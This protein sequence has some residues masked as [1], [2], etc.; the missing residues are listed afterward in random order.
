M[1]GGDKLS[2]KVI[3]PGLLTTVQ[4]LG[5]YG[6]Q[7]YGV[8]V[9]GAMD[10]FSLRVANLLVGNDENAA[11]LEITMMGPTLEILEDTLVSICGG[12]ITAKING[13]PVGQW[14]PVYIKKGSI[15]ELKNCTGG[16]RIYLAIAGGFDV[17]EIMGSKSTY[18]RAGIGGFKGRKL[19]EQDILNTKQYSSESN[20]IIKKFSDFIGKSSFAFSETD[21]S[22]STEIIPK[23]KNDI[24][25]RVIQGIEFDE[26]R[27]ESREEFFTNKFVVTAQSDRMGYRLKGSKLELS[28][29]LEMISG[30]VSFGTIQVPSEGN[31]IVLLADRQTTG[32]YP[33]IAQI[34]SV[35]LP[36]IA[37]AKPGDKI[38]FEQISLEEAQK[39]YIQREL[40]IQKLKH[41]ISLTME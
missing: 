31:P 27:R 40:N 37:Q 20:K 38:S 26:F 24:V 4:D 28:K 41:G 14:K 17:E 18:L 22:V 29:P 3:R 39:L 7:R 1:E 33:K 36:L 10:Q 25:L 5:R 9:S 32:G 8:I 16:C 2:I 12:T 13:Q 34:I 23:Y 19:K 30:A 21:W 15:L 6:S 11:A 35:D